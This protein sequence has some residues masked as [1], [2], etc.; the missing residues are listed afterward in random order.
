M[1]GACDD[2]RGGTWLQ[3]LSGNTR[4]Q[5]FLLHVFPSCH[6]GFATFCPPSTSEVVTAVELQ[7]NFRKE[8]S[9]TTEISDVKLFKA[10]EILGD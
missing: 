3:G 2:V 6:N 8:G 4:E 9:T 10:L 5:D 7:R 1:E